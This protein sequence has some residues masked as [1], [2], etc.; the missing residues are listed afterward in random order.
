M[1]GELELPAKNLDI[2]APRA[3]PLVSLLVVIVNYRTP[4]LMVDCPHSFAPEIGLLPRTSAM[5]V[6]NASGD[7]S[8]DRTWT[9]F[10][11][12][13]RL[14]PR[15]PDFPFTIGSEHMTCPGFPA[16]FRV[17]PR[18]GHQGSPRCG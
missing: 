15:P 4:D 6:D 12:P 11:R 14:L 7:G 17:T 5:V 8:I 2:Q 13:R 10:A 1:T 18:G 3:P 16:A 9:A